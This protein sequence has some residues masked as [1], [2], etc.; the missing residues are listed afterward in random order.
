MGIRQVVISD[1]SGKEIEDG[2]LCELVIR[3][4]PALDAP[5]RLDVAAD[6]VAGLKEASNVVTVEVKVGGEVETKSL[7]LAEF[8]KVVPKKALA[9]GSSTR[10]RRKGTRLNRP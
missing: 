5:K 3:S 2:Q 7:T 10:G 9:N 4:H 1:I 6:E 8:E